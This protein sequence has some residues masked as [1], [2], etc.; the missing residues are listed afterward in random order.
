M[1]SLGDTMTYLEG[2]IAGAE[3]ACAIIMKSLD[4][5]PTDSAAMVRIL[6]EMSKHVAPDSEP[7]FKRGFEVSIKQMTK[8]I[9]SVGKSGIIPHFSRASSGRKEGA[10][11]D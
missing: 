10:K 1:G 3:W 4:G 6:E 7:G 11:A 9:G 5:P 8:S 2:R